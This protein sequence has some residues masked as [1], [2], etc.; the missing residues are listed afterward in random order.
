MQSADVTDFQT[1]SDFSFLIALLC[2]ACESTMEPAEI[3]VKGVMVE[4]AGALPQ[5]VNVGQVHYPGW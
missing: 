3:L 2:H 5:M 1:T 4:L